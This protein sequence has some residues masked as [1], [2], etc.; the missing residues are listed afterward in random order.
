M[1]VLLG[2]LFDMILLS[3]DCY[4]K[5]CLIRQ[6]ALSLDPITRGTVKI[7]EKKLD[8]M[9]NERWDAVNVEPGRGTINRVL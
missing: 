7:E 4:C 2:D 9:I 5:G 1:D 6:R 3:W 8:L